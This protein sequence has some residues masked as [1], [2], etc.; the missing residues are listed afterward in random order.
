MFCDYLPYLTSMTSFVSEKSLPPPTILPRHTP[1]KNGQHDRINLRHRMRLV[2]DNPTMAIAKHDRRPTA[3]CGGKPS[4]RHCC[5]KL[6]PVNISTARPVSGGGI[7]ASE[8]LE[9]TFLH[10]QCWEGL[11]DGRRLCS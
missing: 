5:H 9:M 7:H 2:E 1:T 10:R 6:V 4:I 11:R 8:D 3:L